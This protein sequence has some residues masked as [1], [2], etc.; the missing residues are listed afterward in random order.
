MTKNLKTFCVRQRS[1]QTFETAGHQQ[2][3]DVPNN[4]K[5]CTGHMSERQSSVIEIFGWL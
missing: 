4:P 2:G 3:L 1:P 5:D